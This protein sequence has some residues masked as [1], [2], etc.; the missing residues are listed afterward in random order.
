MDHPL[1]IA[2]RGSRYPRRGVERH[3]SAVVHASSNPT[4][5]TFLIEVDPPFRLD[6]TVWALRRRA[7]NQ[8]DRWDGSEYSRTICVGEA[9]IRLAVRQ[10]EFGT[11]PRL[12]VHAVGSG[13]RVHIRE[14]ARDTLERMLGLRL[15]LAGFYA[16]AATNPPLD[17][18][19]QRFRGMRP[20]RFPSIFE[21]LVNGI[22]CQQ[23]SL[24]AGVT[25]L[26]RLAAT[27]GQVACAAA[28]ED[29]AFP[30]PEVIA[31]ADP[32]A[33]M[34]I[35]FSRAKSA[36]LKEL[37]MSA[38]K[39]DIGDDV[40]ADLDDA[41][42][43]AKLD[44]LRGVGRWTAEYALLRGCG[45]LNIFPGDDVGARNNLQRWLGRRSPLDYDSTRTVL[46]RWQPYAGLVYLHLLLRHLDDEG[47][48]QATVA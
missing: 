21:A 46:R 10:I 4:Q 38:A 18:L 48:L 7:I 32:D 45:R 25:L 5:A 1:S 40:L 42:A 31:A 19:A 34:A 41:T 37:A 8:T 6:L 24:Q 30:A 12:L 17:E 27:Y 20:P 33:L 36:A 16:T 28:P 9:P 26:N 15:D 43:L 11:A 13:G 44:K 14:A 47:V 22:A 23:I 39:G 35:G 29:R 3:Q 2:C